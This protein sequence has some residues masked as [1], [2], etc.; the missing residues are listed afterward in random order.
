MPGVSDSKL[1]FSRRSIFSLF[2]FWNKETFKL[3]LQSPDFVPD[4]SNFVRSIRES[5]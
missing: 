1:L 4:I 3:R 2:N 5:S